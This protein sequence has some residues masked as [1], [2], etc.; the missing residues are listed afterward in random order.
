MTNKFAPSGTDVESVDTFSTG[1]HL[2]DGLKPYI[3][4]ID[5]GA[6]KKTSFKY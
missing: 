6:R 4:K 1:A 3:K 5:I 2:F